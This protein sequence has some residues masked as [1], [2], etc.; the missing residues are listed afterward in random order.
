MLIHYY[1]MKLRT[2]VHVHCLKETV[3]KEIHSEII[4]VYF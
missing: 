1:A 4:K 3:K 2:H